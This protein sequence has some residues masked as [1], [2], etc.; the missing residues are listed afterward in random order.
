M[1][2]LS[3]A[4]ATR[5][6]VLSAM[7]AEHSQF[8]T[9]AP[10]AEQVVAGLRLPDVGTLRVLDLGA[11]AGALTAALIDRI[12]ATI[13]L[14][15]TAVE[16]DADLLPYLSQTLDGL[17]ATILHGDAVDLAVDGTLPDD[18]DVVVM[19]P[20]YGKLAANSA[21]RRRMS[22]LGVET[23]NIY[24]AFMAI[25][26]LSLK[27]GGQMAAI[28]PRSWANGP[29]FKRFRH[30]ML[31]HMSI[32]RI[33]TFASR[34]SLFS[35]AK[36]LQEN[37]IITGTR[38]RQQSGVA[39]VFDAGQPKTLPASDIIVPTDPERFVRIPTGAERELPGAPLSAMGLKV[40][41]GKVVDFRSREHLTEPGVGAFPMVYQGN[42]TQGRVVWPRDIGKPQGFMCEPEEAS[43][44][45][46]P[47]GVYVVVKRFTAK[48]ERRRIVAAVHEPDTPVAYDNKTNVITCPDRDVAVGLALWLNSTAVDTYFRAFSGHTQVNAT[49]LRVMPYP[50]IDQMRELGR[51]CDAVMPSQDDIDTAVEGLL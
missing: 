29:Y 3:V 6:A 35:D 15:I 48:E 45:L 50:T 4:E 36:V 34:S 20:P 43:K 39:L 10:L 9:P 38:N 11:G 41:T 32:D 33:Q 30:H 23:P 17:G 8:F 27:Q 26:Y 12:P 44:F 37:V 7:K 25:G 40:S 24:A 14:D 47:E 51:G 5:T 31:D 21:S 22:H 19:N 13:K 28:V 42:I 1:T 18:F 49:D 2:L 46:V 16:L